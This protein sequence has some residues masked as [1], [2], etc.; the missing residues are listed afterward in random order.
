MYNTPFTK[1][2]H[3][4][5]KDVV[6]LSD[7]QSFHSS[8]NTRDHDSPFDNQEQFAFYDLDFHTEAPVLT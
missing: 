6:L 5:Q 2:E 1:S 7:P 4:I 8:R 3:T